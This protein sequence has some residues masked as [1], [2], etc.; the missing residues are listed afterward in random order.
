MSKLT[1]QEKN[2][3]S[4]IQDLIKQYEACL[5]EYQSEVK[6][7]SKTDNKRLS[8]SLDEDTPKLR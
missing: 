7:L 4:T 5:K 6:K 2:E 3:I 1:E 8:P